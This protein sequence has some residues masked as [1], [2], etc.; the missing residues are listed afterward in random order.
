[1]PVAE[2]LGNLSGRKIFRRFPGRGGDRRLHQRDVGDAS[3]AVPASADEAAQGGVGGEQRAEHVGRLHA[4]PR[5][6][7][8]RLAGHRQRAREGLD[9]QVDAGAA[10]VRPGLAEAGHRRIDKARIDGAQR[11]RAQSQLVQ[12]ARPVGFQEHV[13]LRGELEHDGARRVLLE[14]EHEAPLVAVERREAHALAVAQGR[15]GAAHV[16]R[17][18]LDL[19]HVGAHVGEQR[20]GE[21]A[22]NEVG[23]LDHPYP[24]ERLRHCVSLGPLVAC[25]YANGRAQRHVAIAGASRQY[26]APR[27]HGAGRWI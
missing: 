26:S 8:A 11:I 21:R 13:R 10:P 4:G 16:A 9:D 25:H 7:P 27:G 5:R 20:P 18:R 1:V 15:R 14:V 24:F 6:H 22:G 2:R 12:R 19:D 23:K 17:R 3:L